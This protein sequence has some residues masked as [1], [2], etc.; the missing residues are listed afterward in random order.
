MGEF[1]K[2]MLCLAFILA[3]PLVCIYLFDLA[4]DRLKCWHWRHDQIG[5]DMKRGLEGALR[6]GW[7]ERDALMVRDRYPNR[8]EL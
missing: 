1:A 3:C 7:L 4:W 6:R 2:N 5:Y 8:S